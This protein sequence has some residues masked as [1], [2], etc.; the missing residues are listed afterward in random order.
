MKKYY[1]R[2]PI[3]NFL[4]TNL[5]FFGIQWRLAYLR[6]KNFIKRSLK[7]TRY[8]TVNQP[9]LSV[10]L[11]EYLAVGYDKLNIGG[12]RKNLHGFVN[13]DFIFHPEVERELTA[14]ILDLSFIPD[15]SISQI[16]SNHVVEHLSP[17]EFVDQLRQWKRILKPS[18]ILTVR[19]PNVLGVCYGFLFPPVPEANRQE[20]LNQGF[21]DDEEFQNPLDDWY[22]HDI[23]G[24]VHW[25]YG[26][27]GNPANEHLNLLTPTK[28]RKTIEGAGF[29]ILKLTEPESSNIVAIAKKV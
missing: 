12:G 17:D 20:F 28:L 25:M 3:I 1:G 7:P 6:L 26:D 23:Y 19:C 13:I 10:A 24:F 5:F 22:H 4:L 11:G 2:F 16:H 8:V 9:N 18:G 29:E 15:G 14:N 27:A 21:P